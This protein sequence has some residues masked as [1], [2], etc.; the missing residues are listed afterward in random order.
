MSCKNMAAFFATSDCYSPEETK[1]QTISL[2]L[3]YALDVFTDLLGK[4]FS[5]SELHVADKL[6]Q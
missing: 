6:P 3:A 4:P 1:A 5:S 2:F